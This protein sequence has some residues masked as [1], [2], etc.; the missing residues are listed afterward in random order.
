MLATVKG[1][2]YLTLSEC[3]QELF[4]AV[5]QRRASLCYRKRRC[6]QSE[7]NTWVRF[8]PISFEHQHANECRMYMQCDEGIHVIV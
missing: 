7:L 8:Q 5:R 2:K 6:W 4:T 3:D 1:T